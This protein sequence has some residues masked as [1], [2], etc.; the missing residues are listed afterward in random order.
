VRDQQP[1]RVLFVCVQ[2]AGRSQM[3][4]ALFNLRADGRA[5]AQSAGTRPAPRVHPVVVRAMR[6]IGLDLDSATPRPLTPELAAGVARV[7]TMGCGDECPVLGAPTEDWALPD[8]STLGLPAVRMIR[9]E[10]DARVQGLLKELQGP[11][12][13]GS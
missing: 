7:V 3:A 13:K 10:I 8:P 5:S 9:D 1:P 11:N 4:A 2:N 12:V 6:E